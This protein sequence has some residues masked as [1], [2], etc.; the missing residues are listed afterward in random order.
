MTRVEV[1]RHIAAEPASVAL[2]LA[3]P[4]TVVDHEHSVVVGVPRRAG[5]GFIA[6]I[7]VVAGGRLLPGHVVVEPAADAGCD[8]RFSARATDCSTTRAI[9]RSGGSFLSDLAIRARARS[10]AA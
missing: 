1:T 6:A 8:V 9:E 4:A 3:G 2:L 7:E 5:V 10:Y